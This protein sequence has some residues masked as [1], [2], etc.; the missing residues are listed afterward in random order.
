[1]MRKPEAQD[2]AR[3][4]KSNLENTFFSILEANPPGWYQDD[5]EKRLDTKMMAGLCKD[6]A[7]RNKDLGQDGARMIGPKI[8]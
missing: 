1:M 4:I 3:M 8:M 5:A 2:D 7:Q 6:D